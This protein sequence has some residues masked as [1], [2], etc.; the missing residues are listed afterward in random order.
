M[1][2]S[3]LQA[4]DVRDALATVGLLQDVLKLPDGLN[5]VLQTDGGPLSSSQAHRLM[6][7]RAIVGRPRLLVIDSTMDG[8]PDDDIR[9]LMRRLTADKMPWTLL[10]VSARTAVME[11]CDRVFDIVENC[12]AIQGSVRGAISDKHGSQI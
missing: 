11:S 12:A 1:N 3:N 7:A 2:R 6:I 9:E 4:K 8:L 10:I 5:T